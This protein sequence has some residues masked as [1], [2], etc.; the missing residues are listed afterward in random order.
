[1]VGLCSRS[2]MFFFLFFF[3]GE[4]MKIAKRIRVGAF[5]STYP[6]A[7]IIE[8]PT[9]ISAFLLSDTLRIAF[10][11]HPQCILEVR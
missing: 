4:V 9:N 3:T 2:T 11:P 8:V 7:V 1:M 10:Y 6:K 5:V